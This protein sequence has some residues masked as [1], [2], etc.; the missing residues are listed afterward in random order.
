MLMI[1]RRAQGVAGEVS[2][3]LRQ[4]VK[5]SLQ[6]VEFPPFAPLP[7][8]VEVPVV[9]LD[10]FQGVDE[11]GTLTAPPVFRS[12][13]T[14]PPDGSVEVGSAV[15]IDEPHVLHSASCPVHGEDPPEIL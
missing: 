11:Q 8:A 2:G 1:T 4:F 13:S 9:S 14:G 7:P 6:D 5:G 12:D 10:G 3:S 15:A